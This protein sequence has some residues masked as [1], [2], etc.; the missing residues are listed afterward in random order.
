MTLYRPK[1]QRQRHGQNL[2]ATFFDSYCMCVTETTT[3]TN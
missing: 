1:I 2:V 3:L